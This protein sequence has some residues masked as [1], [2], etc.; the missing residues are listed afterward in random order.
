MGALTGN[1]ATARS[2]AAVRIPER[3]TIVEGNGCEFE[4]KAQVRGRRSSLSKRRVPPLAHHG[5][6]RIISVIRSYQCGWWGMTGKVGR[7]RTPEAR[8]RFFELY[9]RAVEEV[10][11]VPA[12][13][14]DVETSFGTTHARRSGSGKGWPLLL[15]HGHTGTSV[16]WATS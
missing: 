2:G 14:L 9:D 13:E 16:G 11:P 7:F 8:E 10:W 12:E 1:V 6:G 4:A 3:Q 5:Y 15:V